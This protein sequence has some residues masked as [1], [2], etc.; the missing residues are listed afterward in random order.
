MSCGCCLATTQPSLSR[1][2]GA[3]LYRDAIM[4]T[5]G[6]FPLLV[7]QHVVETPTHEWGGER[8]L[9][10]RCRSVRGCLSSSRSYAY[11][12]SH[13][14]GADLDVQ[15]VGTSGVGGDS[16]G[17]ETALYAQPWRRLPVIDLS[18]SPGRRQLQQG[19]NFPTFSPRRAL[20]SVS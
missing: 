3:E 11:F 4:T 18:R 16:Y 7:E 20:T 2:A 15:C 14:A 17:C 10:G 8:C 9:N 1:I 13:N 6:S 5:R 19:F 12:S